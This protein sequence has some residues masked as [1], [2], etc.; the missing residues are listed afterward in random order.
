MKI[1]AWEDIPDNLTEEK[2]DPGKWRG[3][4]G[5]RKQGIGEDFYLGHPNAGLFQFKIFTK[6]PFK[7]KGVGAKIS[8]NIDSE[9]Q[10]YLQIR[11]LDILQFINLQ[12]IKKKRKRG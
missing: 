12:K 9:N 8:K 2:V 5:K 11:I 7:I 4:A 6:N 1:R 3:T 10:I